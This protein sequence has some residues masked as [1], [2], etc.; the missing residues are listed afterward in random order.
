MHMGLRLEMEQGW[1]FGS[2]AEE[3]TN[4]VMPPLYWPVEFFPQTMETHLLDRQ[5]FYDDP[6]TKRLYLEVA[7][8]IKEGD[9]LILRVPKPVEVVYP[10]GLI[11]SKKIAGRLEIEELAQRVWNAS[12]RV[13]QNRSNELS[14]RRFGSGNH[15][16]APRAYIGT[17]VLPQPKRK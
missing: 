1:P 16:T 13:E 4:G 2:N 12:T 3:I 10:S 9:V 15:K 17:L 6:T 5:E 14:I 11:A 7:V 8:E